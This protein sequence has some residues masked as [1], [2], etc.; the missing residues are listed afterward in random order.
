MFKVNSKNTKTTSLRSLCLYFKLC[1]N[2]VY[3]FSVSIVEFAQV[4]AEWVAKMTPFVSRHSGSSFG[5][6]KARS[7]LVLCILAKLKTMLWNFIRFFIVTVGIQIE[8]VF[9]KRHNTKRH[10]N[11][12]KLLRSLLYRASDSVQCDSNSRGGEWGSEPPQGFLQRAKSWRTFYLI[13]NFHFLEE[14]ENYWVKN[15]HKTFSWIPHTHEK[16]QTT[17]NDWSY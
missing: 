11:F 4:N 5:V 13:F 12:K 16:E 7:N 8:K 17:T 15:Y 10:A 3:F 2:L 6:K 14:F 9:F 1:K